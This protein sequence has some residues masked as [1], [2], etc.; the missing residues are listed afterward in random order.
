MRRDRRTVREETIQW[1]LTGSIR[2]IAL[3]LFAFAVISLFVLVARSAPQNQR[4]QSNTGQ[5]PATT[6]WKE[7]AQALGKEGSV[8]P[9]DVYKVSLPRSDLKV[10]VNGSRTQTSTRPWFVGGVQKEQAT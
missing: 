7:V 8:Q 9:G 6:G 1:F 2:R 3:S 10:T 5:Q 4:G